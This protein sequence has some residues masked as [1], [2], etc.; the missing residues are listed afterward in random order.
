M[1]GTKYDVVEE[2]KRK[3]QVDYHFVTDFAETLTNDARV[4][5]T[6]ARSGYRVHELFEEIAKDFARAKATAASNKDQQDLSTAENT[7]DLNH[8][9]TDL[10]NCLEVKLQTMPLLLAQQQNRT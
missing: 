6:S 7:A 2:N 8:C 4:F 1:C 9:S 10:L 3:R 5:E